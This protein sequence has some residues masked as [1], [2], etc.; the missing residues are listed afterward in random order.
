MSIETDLFAALK[1]LAP[2][3]PTIAPQG[4]VGP[5]IT[6]QRVAGSDVPN[7][8][9]DGSGATSARIQVDVWADNY[10]AARAL[11]D[12]ARAALY[13]ALTVGEITDNPSDYEAE[14]KLH[15]ASFDVAAWA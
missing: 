1:V 7:Y 4:T 11:A 12:Q 5:R 3:W 8:D 10:G 9:A 14:T 15:R 13:A 2:T 6:Y